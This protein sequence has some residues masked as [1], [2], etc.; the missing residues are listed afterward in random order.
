MQKTRLLKRVFCEY[1]PV[2]WGIL[3]IKRQSSGKMGASGSGGD[4]EGE[5]V[6]SGVEEGDALGVASALG[7]GEGS[8]SPPMVTVAEGGPL[9]PSRSGTT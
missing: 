2:P 6:T 5:G 4:G 7:L 8:I 1:F 9:F 3:S